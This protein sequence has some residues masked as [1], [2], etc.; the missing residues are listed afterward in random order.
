VSISSRFMAIG[1]TFLAASILVFRFSNAD[2]LAWVLMALSFPPIM[3]AA[4][5]GQAQQ[6]AGM[7]YDL[8]PDDLRDAYKASSAAPRLV[9]L[10]IWFFGMLIARELQA[11]PDNGW[12]AVVIFA[13][14]IVW[15]ALL[16]LSHSK[17]IIAY[18][19]ERASAGIE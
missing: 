8:Y 2:L 14:F 16:Y 7:R 18:M 6:L 9:F 4:A 19:A 10:Y 12:V 3:E 1:A 5:W 13:P 15:L 17:T 11:L